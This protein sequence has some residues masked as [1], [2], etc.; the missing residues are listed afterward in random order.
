MTQKEEKK[1]QKTDD[2][3]QTKKPVND[4]ARPQN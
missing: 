4:K 2:K 3:R 1:N